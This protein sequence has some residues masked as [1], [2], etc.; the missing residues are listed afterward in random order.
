MRPPTFSSSTIEAYQRCPR[1]YA[2]DSI[3]HFSGDPNGYQLFRMATRKTVEELRKRCQ[4]THTSESDHQRVPT[5][6]E[7][8]ELYT[9]YWQELDGHTTPFTTLYEQH[10][11]EV[12]EALRRK[13]ITQTEINWDLHIGLD[14]EIADTAVRITIDRVETDNQASTPVRFVRTRFGKSKEK[15]TAQTR[16][17][18]YILAYRQLHPGQSVELHS[19]NMSTDQVTSIKLTQKKEQSLYENVER[20]ITGLQA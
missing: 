15:A 20:A 10:G 12:V 5:Q 7:I 16:E 17:L 6:Q 1:Q 19:H 9:Q 2:Y 11:Q 3:Y 18:L 13:I 8:Q 4:D 14:V